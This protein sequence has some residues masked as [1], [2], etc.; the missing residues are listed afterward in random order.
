M[1]MVW[2]QL[3]FQNLALPAVCQFLKY[4]LKILAKLGMGLFVAGL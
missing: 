3:P 1:L 2:H 4:L